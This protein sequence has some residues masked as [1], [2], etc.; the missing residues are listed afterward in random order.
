MNSPGPVNTGKGCRVVDYSDSASSV[1]AGVVRHFHF[2]YNDM[3]Q[4]IFFGEE[5]V[6]HYELSYD[7]LG[8]I[9]KINHFQGN[10]PAPPSFTVLY[11]G[12]FVT[13]LNFLDGSGNTTFSET[14]SWNSGG[15][16]ELDKVDIPKTQ[17]SS[18]GYLA[19]VYSQNQGFAE[20]HA[21]S[22]DPLDPY[23]RIMVQSIPVNIRPAV[24]NPFFINTTKDE[25]FL[26]WLFLNG[27]GPIGNLSAL[28]GGGW[29]DDILSFY[30]YDANG[31]KSTF[32]HEKF[33]FILDS[34]N[35][36]IK[37][38]AYVAKDPP[39]FSNYVKFDE[40]IIAY[41]CK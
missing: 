21:G 30:T 10:L 19:F 35:N 22:T 27:F 1:V 17:F 6:F 3:D 2:Q 37:R 39:G 12:D 33:E 9:S 40:N 23:D 7:A 26:Y 34:N 29:N 41:Q 11:T 13:Q 4:L 15:F 14:L 36:V 38:I 5:N 32:S 31:Q 8:H 20:Y 18:P 16:G 28:N 25:R 24:A